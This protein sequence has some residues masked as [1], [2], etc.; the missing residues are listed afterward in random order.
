MSQRSSSNNKSLITLGNRVGK[1]YID[2]GLVILSFST[3]L[4]LIGVVNILLNRPH[5][6]DEQ[7]VTPT[8]NSS[9][10]ITSVRPPESTNPITTLGPIS[11]WN[12]LN[13]NADGYQIK[14]PNNWFDKGE[15]YATDGFYE[16]VIMSEDTQWND[17]N[18]QG[19]YISIRK[20]TRDLPYGNNERLSPEEYFEKYTI[21]WDGAER[22]TIDNQPALFLIQNV[23]TIP[24]EKEQ[25]DL[26]GNYKILY[27]S[28]V[29]YEITYTSP[30]YATA[31]EN[32]STFEEMVHSIKF[33]E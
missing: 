20:R 32:L 13:N 5:I 18:F 3:V 31:Q 16:H 23:P 10:P 9:I 14:Y 4:A 26:V 28:K 17:P 29:L 33:I 8:N 30:N 24:G 1:H 7:N 22:V 12:T 6:N 27:D 21:V 11:V 25:F 19:V 15:T 2:I